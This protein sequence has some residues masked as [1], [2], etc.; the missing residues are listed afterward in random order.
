MSGPF[1]LS[2]S[3]HLNEVFDDGLKQCAEADPFPTRIRVTGVSMNIVD[4]IVD[5]LAEMY[6]TSF[7]EAWRIYVETYCFSD[8]E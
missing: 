5:Q 4:Q 3:V 6:H 7:E 8:Y 1:R 2:V